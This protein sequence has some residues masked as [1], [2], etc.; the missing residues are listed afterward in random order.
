MSG[1]WAVA[2]PAATGGPDDPPIKSGEGHD[3]EGEPWGDDFGVHNRLH[4][5]MA[6]L[7]RFGILANCLL[8]GL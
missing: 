2:A 6:Q 7:D 5:A 8:R 3:D 1:V 4:D